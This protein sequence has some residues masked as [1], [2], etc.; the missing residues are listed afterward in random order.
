VPADPSSSILSG[1]TPLCDAGPL[2]AVETPQLLAYL[3]TITDPRARAGRRH[4]LVA[5]LVLAAAA[6]LAGARSFTAI[7]EWAADA[8]NRSVPRSAPDAIPAAAWVPGGHQAGL[9]PVHGQ[10]QPAHAPG[11]LRRPARHR[12]P[13]LDRTGDRAHGRVELRTLT[14]VSVSRFGF[15]H[16]AQ[17]VQVTRTAR[18][19]RQHYTKR[20]RTVTAYAITSLAFERASP[21]RLAD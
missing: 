2:R 14:A 18:D 8:P 1:L 15:P 21:A 4:P 13:E 9:L 10:G 19:L 12:V 3:A 6:V 5:I 17:V 16:A 11:P 7:A 20:W